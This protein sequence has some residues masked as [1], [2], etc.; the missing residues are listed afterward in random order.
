MLTSGTRTC[1]RC[2]GQ[3]HYFALVSQH[4]DRKEWTTCDLCN[5]KGKRHFMS[6]AEENDYWEDYW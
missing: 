6:E 5:G 1:T 2:N 3:G 4:D